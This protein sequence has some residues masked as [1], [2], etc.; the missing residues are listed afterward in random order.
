MRRADRP[1]EL[2][3]LA[4]RKFS[5]SEQVWGRLLRLRL[6]AGTGGGGGGNRMAIVYPFFDCDIGYRDDMFG[7]V[8]C[9]PHRSRRVRGLLLRVVCLC[10]R[11][12]ERVW[13]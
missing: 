5:R 6:T 9:V 4:A 12:N 13:Y 10:I 7:S 8:S 2:L 11:Y 3:E 1:V